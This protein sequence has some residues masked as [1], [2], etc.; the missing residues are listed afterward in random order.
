[1]PG[2]A[3]HRTG[4]KSTGSQSRRPTLSPEPGTRWRRA[5]PPRPRSTAP[6]VLALRCSPTRRARSALLS[7]RRR[8]STPEPRKAGLVLSVRPKGKLEATR[9][10]TDKVQ[11]HSQGLPSSAPHHDLTPAY[12]S[13]SLFKCCSSPIALLWVPLLHCACASWPWYLL[14]PCLE[15]PAPPSLLPPTCPSPHVENSSKSSTTLRCH[16]LHQAHF[17]HLPPLS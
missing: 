13:G 5:S 2:A 15:S 8:L 6:S 9:V 16:S 7:L 17:D 3:T 12:S 1:M 10:L 4:L 11:I 14:F